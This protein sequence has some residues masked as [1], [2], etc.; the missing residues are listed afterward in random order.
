MRERKRRFRENMFFLGENP[1]KLK[2]LLQVI[3]N[4]KILAL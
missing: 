2:V 4:A 1:E 3:K